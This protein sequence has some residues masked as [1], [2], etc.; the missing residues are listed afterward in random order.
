[1]QDL[2]AVIGAGMAY[3]T[4][5]RKIDYKQL[6]N[7]WPKDIAACRQK[8][9]VKDKLYPIEILE[10]DPNSSRVKLRILAILVTMTNGVVVMKL[11]I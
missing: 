7:P 8:K 2:A 6:S 3:N 10:R 11:W 4:R 1:M 9:Q 5:R